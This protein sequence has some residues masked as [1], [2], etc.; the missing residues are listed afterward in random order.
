[1]VND[2]FESGQSEIQLIIFKLGNEEYAVPIMCVQEIIMLQNSTRIPKSPDFVEGVINLRGHIIPV[3]DGRK[4]FNL[5]QSSANNIAD[6]RIMVLEVEE[7]TIGLIVDAV[8]EVIHLK[9]DDI[10]PP[11]VDMGEDSDLLWGVGKFDNRLLILLNTEKFLNIQEVTDVK[12]LA[13]M[14]EV[15]KQANE[16]GIETKELYEL[17]S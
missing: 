1:M 4:K 17:K 6:Q 2:F 11:P 3:I 16:I 10:E 9:K 7:D 15:I 14:T 5:K 12:K 13:K 8:S